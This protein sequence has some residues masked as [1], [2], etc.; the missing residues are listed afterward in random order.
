M[1]RNKT[2]KPDVPKNPRSAFLFFSQEERE[3]IKEKNPK[4][5]FAEFGKILGEMWQEMSQEKKKKYEEKARIDKQRYQ[6]EVKAYLAKGGKAEDLKK[7]ERKT[8]KKTKKDPNAPKRPSTAYIFFS[9]EM[10]H[11]LKTENPKAS[12]TEAGKIIGIQWKELDDVAKQKYHQLAEADKQRFEKEKGEYKEAEES[13]EEEEP[14]A[15]KPA[16]S[17][18][19]TKKPPVEEEDDDDDDEESSESE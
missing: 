17:K 4:T 11:K 8:V 7:K 5:K 14:E 12:F 10:R 18:T 1:P 6:D 2:S 13:N 9:K 19:A 15:K 16:T 3:K